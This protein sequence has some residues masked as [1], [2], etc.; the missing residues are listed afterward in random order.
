VGTKLAK[1]LTIVAPKQ[2]PQIQTEIR[3]PMYVEKL[4]SAKGLKR[5]V[6]EG[7]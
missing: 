1:R 2:H 4:A 3:K 7:F 5:K 6:E